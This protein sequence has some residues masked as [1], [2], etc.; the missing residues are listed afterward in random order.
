MLNLVQR[1]ILGCLLLTALVV[2]LVA[3]THHALTAAGQFH[4][5]IAFVITVV[6]V[7][8]GTVLLVLHPIRMVARDAKKIAQGNVD[9]R[10]EWSSRDDFGV[11]ASELNRIAV[12]LRELRESEAGRRQME[13]QLSD[14]VLQ[15]IFEPII[16]TDAKGHILKVNQAAIEVLGE[17]A[18]DRMALTNTPGGDKILSAI[19]DAVAMQKPVAA[20]DDAAVLPMRIGKQSRSFRLRTTTPRAD[21]WAPSPRS[22]M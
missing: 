21:C 22:K 3:V 16:V 1:L 8:L 9:H 4:L 18:T 12:R 5:A 13:F 15:S 20:E 11:I 2:G 10:V 7:E 19:R 6:L 17:A 14:A